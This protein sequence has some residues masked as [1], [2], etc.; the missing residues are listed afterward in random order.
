[1]VTNNKKAILF[2]TKNQTEQEYLAEYLDKKWLFVNWWQNGYNLKKL[3]L[4]TDN[5]K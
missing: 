4:S 2:P 3:L 5:L 1:L